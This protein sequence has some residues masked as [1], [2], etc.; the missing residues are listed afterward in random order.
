[1]AVGVLFVDRTSVGIK[2]KRMSSIANRKSPHDR[3]KTPQ[4][5][6]FRDVHN[7]A[8]DDNVLPANI[9]DPD[10]LRSTAPDGFMVRFEE[11][12]WSTTRRVKYWLVVRRVGQNHT[13]KKLIKV[14]PR[15]KNIFKHSE[16]KRECPPVGND[17]RAH[18]GGAST[19]LPH[20]LVRF[21][22]VSLLEKLDPKIQPTSF[23]CAIGAYV[24]IH[25][26]TK[27]PVSDVFLFPAS[28]AYH[29]FPPKLLLNR[30]TCLSLLSSSHGFLQTTFH[31][32]LQNRTSAS[33]MPV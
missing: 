30:N 24:D 11:N 13:A 31:G 18:L 23:G 10:Q 14:T 27:D 20:I 1:M 26:V 6:M 29:F 16:D 17:P 19:G 8:C 5:Q 25:D 12:R 22:T 9:V 7:H 15:S 33:M 21:L 3:L 4:P 32:S 2:H 28:T